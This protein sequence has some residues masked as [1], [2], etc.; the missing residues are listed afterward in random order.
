MLPGDALP[1]RMPLLTTGLSNPCQR[2]MSA[3]GISMRFSGA[4]PCTYALKTIAFGRTDL[5]SIVASNKRKVPSTLHSLLQ[6]RT[7]CQLLS[8]G[9]IAPRAVSGLLSAT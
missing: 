2:V 5:P 1:T 7:S 4:S 8:C 9:S 3:S 6:T